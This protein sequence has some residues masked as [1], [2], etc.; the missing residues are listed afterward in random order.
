LCARQ[1]FLEEAN[2]FDEIDVSDPELRRRCWKNGRLTVRRF[3]NGKSIGG[4]DE[5]ALDR[6]G[7]LER[8]LGLSESPTGTSD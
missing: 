5:L 6:S 7:D 1:G 3:I 8:L 4:C 2:P